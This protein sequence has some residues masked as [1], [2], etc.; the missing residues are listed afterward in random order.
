MNILRVSAAAFF[1]FISSQSYAADPIRDYS[2]QGDTTIMSVPRKAVENP[3]CTSDYGS[4][5]SS[6]ECC[7]QGASC[8][9]IG[10]YG[11]NVCDPPG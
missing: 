1:V 10:A 2:R 8:Q 11:G 3:S 5:S 9:R 7:T 6:S 4:C